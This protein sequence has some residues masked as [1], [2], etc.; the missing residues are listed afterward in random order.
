MPMSSSA[1]CRRAALV[2]SGLAAVC[3]PAA[4]ADT[5]FVK[6][7]QAHGG[8]GTFLSLVSRAGL[9]DTLGAAP[10][11]VFM[12]TDGAFS[13]LPAAQRTSI[14]ALSPEGLKVLL[15]R[16]VFSGTA[17]ASNDV[18]KTITS[19]NGTVFDVTWYV[20]RLSLRDH[21]APATGRLAYVVQGDI[22][23]GPGV[24]EA[25]DAVLMPAAPAV[26]VPSASAVPGT[27]A[28]TLVPAPASA[29]PAPGATASAVPGTPA[30]T[31]V[32]AA[33]PATPASGA[34]ASAIPGT[35]VP[36]PVPPPAAMAEQQAPKPG[37]GSQIAASAPSPAMPGAVAPVVAAPAAP[38]VS[39]AAAGLRGWPLKVSGNGSTGKVNGVM[40]GLPDGRVTGLSAHFGGFLGFGG[41]NVFVSWSRVTPD[42]K[43]HVLRAHMTA[44]EFAAAPAVPPKP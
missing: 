19:E 15:G 16:F 32:P 12:P 7:A 11:T 13:R 34:T 1:A 8:F 39:I 5:D 4:A 41:R 31:P 14:D 2:V 18:D 25:V 37:A 44:A 24:I 27:L 20:G 43:A 22:P 17:M 28:P 35:P 10:V 23:A 30:P 33:A 9:A 3:R 40:I 6:A 38:E 29:M 26:A 42:A 36:T 21:R